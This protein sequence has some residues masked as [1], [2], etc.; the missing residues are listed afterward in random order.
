MGV[1]RP[2]QVLYF[3]DSEENEQ[4]SEIVSMFRGVGQETR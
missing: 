1:L 3:E 4:L 2:V